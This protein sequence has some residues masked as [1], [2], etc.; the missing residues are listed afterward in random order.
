MS[1]P[2]VRLV[3]MVGH[4]DV[5]HHRPPDVER[6]PS[7]DGTA[8]VEEPDESLVQR[9]G[10]GRVLIERVG[11]QGGDGAHP[12]ASQS[13]VSTDRGQLLAPQRRGTRTGREV[14]GC[15]ASTG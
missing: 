10:K 11:C 13:E 15:H 3:A 5:L 4:I 1:R 14:P 7:P 6:V 12:G 2:L 8:W 9:W